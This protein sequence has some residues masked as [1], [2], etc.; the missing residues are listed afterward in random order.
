MITDADADAAERFRSSGVRGRAVVALARLQLA[1]CAS[2]K[3]SGTAQGPAAAATDRLNTTYTVTCDGIVPDGFHATVVNGAARVPADGGRPP[4]YEHHDIRVTATAG[5]DVDGDG[6]PDAVVLLDCSP[7]PSNGILHDVRSGSV[8]SER[9]GV[10]GVRQP[11]RLT[12]VQP[13]RDRDGAGRYPAPSS[14]SR[15]ETGDRWW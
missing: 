13:G 4:Y 1:G 3:P 12:T 6:A 9:F 14:A 2:A 5:G 11:P 8:C 15:S 10:L 7:Q